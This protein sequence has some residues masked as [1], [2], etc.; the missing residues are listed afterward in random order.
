MNKEKKKRREKQKVSTLGYFSNYV[1]D[2]IKLITGLGVFAT[3]TAL[4]L[5]LDINQFGESL[6][7]LQL[8]LLVLLFIFLAFFSAITVAWIIKNAD[9]YFGSIIFITLLLLLYFFGRFILSNYSSEFRSYTGWIGGVVSLMILGWLI[10]LFTGIVRKINDSKYKNVFLVFGGFFIYIIFFGLHHI[11]STYSNLGT[12]GFSNLLSYLF[13]PTVLIL[14]TWFVFIDLVTT[15]V[16]Q[17]P[18][19]WQIFLLFS[20]VVVY[21]VYIVY[22]IYL[23]IRY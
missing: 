20:P 11:F 21:L 9:S 16:W 7:F 2:N 13:S 17:K 14:I 23:A 3:I 4:F 6:R 5:N 22:L 1:S 18:K 15:Y 19:K 8:L 10:S 12:L